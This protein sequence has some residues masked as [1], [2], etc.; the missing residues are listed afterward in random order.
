MKGEAALN[1]VLKELHVIFERFGVRW[2]LFGAQAQNI[3]GRSR[4]T[5]DVD[6]TVEWVAGSNAELIKV[7]EDRGFKLR[8][9]EDVEEFVA[10]SHVFPV[11]HLQ[12]GIP[13]DVVLAQPGFEDVFMGRTKLVEFGDVQI[14]VVSPED[15]IVMKLLAGRSQDVLDVRGILIDRMDALDLD[16]IRTDLHNLEESLGQSD[17]I[18]VF[19]GEAEAAEQLRQ[20]EERV[21]GNQGNKNDK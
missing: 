11:V 7:L 8:V 5:A 21:F 18:R 10:L 9:Q 17:L 13:V 19:E 14:P 6:V 2:F 15:L 20:H 1:N 12:T 16:R 3:W 4:L